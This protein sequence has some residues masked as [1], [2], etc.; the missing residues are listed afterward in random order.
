[1][2]GASPAARGGRFGKGGGAVV[3]A[4]D[5]GEGIRAVIVDFAGVLSAP[6]SESFAA[7]Q[8]YLE[9][10]IEEIRFAMAREE[11]RTGQYLLF[12]L[13]RGRIGSDEFVRRLE[14]HF[15]CM[16][17]DRLFDVYYEYHYANTEM[18]DF[19]RELRDRGYRTALLT[20]AGRE[21]EPAWRTIIGDV[22]GLFDACVFSWR[23]GLRKPEREIYELTMRR[24]GSDLVPSQCLVIDDFAVNCEAARRLGMKAVLFRDTEQAKA[25]TRELLGLAAPQPAAAHG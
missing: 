1:M 22:D 20:N 24:T 9:V 14:A 12:E 17:F 7:F 4:P 3:S 2:S 19:V 25:E 13:E 18:I 21:W 5:G 6:L 16:K 23:T 11:E 15:A 10:T 8:K